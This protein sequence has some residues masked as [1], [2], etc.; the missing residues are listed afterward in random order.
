MLTRWSDRFLAVA[1][2][3]YALISL[4]YTYPQVWGHV[5]NGQRVSYEL[6]VVLALAS[7]GM[8]RFPRHLKAGV[9]IC[10]AGAVVFILYGAHDAFAI[11][12]GLMP[13]K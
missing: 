9:A 12:D 4:S 13:W 7:L 2:I 1:L 8:H 6:F 11:R 10:W 3:V 5:G